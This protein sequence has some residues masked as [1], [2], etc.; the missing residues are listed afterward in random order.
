MYILYFALSFCLCKEI[1][2]LM[3][4]LGGKMQSFLRKNSTYISYYITH[5]NTVFC[6]ITENVAENSLGQKLFFLSPDITKNLPG[7]AGFF[8]KRFKTI[9][10]TFSRKASS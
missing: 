6:I 7:L 1:E 9:F 2:M 5:F 8:F 4:I 3:Q 10:A